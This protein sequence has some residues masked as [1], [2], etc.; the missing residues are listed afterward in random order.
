MSVTPEKR[1]DTKFRKRI[2]RRFHYGDMADL[3][4]PSLPLTE[5]SVDYFHDSAPGKLGHVDLEVASN[6]V[7]QNKVTPCSMVVSVLYAR[8]LRQRNTKYLDSM[9]TSDVFFISMMMAS[10]YMYDEGT[11]DEVYNDEWAASVDQEVSDVNKM[12][13]D[14][15][16]AMDW[17]LFVDPQEFEDALGAIEKRMALKEGWKR[18]W[19]TYTEMDV[20]M[21]PDLIGMLWCDFTAEVSKM[22]AALATAYVTSLLSMLGSVVV[23]TQVASPLSSAA[24]ALVALNIHSSP[25]LMFPLDKDA[26]LLEVPNPGI[27]LC[28]FQNP[29]GSCHVTFAAHDVDPEINYTDSVETKVVFQTS[30][31]LKDLPA[32]AGVY[33]DTKDMVDL[34]LK[35]PGKLRVEKN[36]QR[37]R[38]R[39]KFNRRRKDQTQNTVGGTKP[40]VS[41][42]SHNVVAS[43]LWSVWLLD[44][45]LSQILS[46]RNHK[47]NSV[48]PKACW[49]QRN[50]LDGPKND[51]FDLKILESLPRQSNNNLH[52]ASF[53]QVEHV[54]GSVGP[55]TYSY[56]AS[57]TKRLKTAP[58]HSY[59]T[60]FP[61][62][63]LFT[64]KDC[65]LY[66]INELCHGIVF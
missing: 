50:L 22:L 49:H 58:D 14:F 13:M 34:K 31:R 16:Q 62:V 7:R 65:S 12:E 30:H 57:A 46:K 23:A 28:G 2:K 44:S 17:R 47:P 32:P 33:L 20:L 15:L 29:A 6:I 48:R 55:L 59:S 4:V 18:G 42:S 60:V 43:S 26:G 5:L 8:R 37:E 38:R 27:N 54:F 11:D 10:K 53:C 51:D 21:G 19:F 41:T 56:P 64:E 36:L 52:H 40:E 66:P 39:A 35:H 9:S 61:A 3:D 45:L 1:L 25:K 63:D 24:V